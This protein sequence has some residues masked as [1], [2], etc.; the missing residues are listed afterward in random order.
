MTQNQ[1]AKKPLIKTVMIQVRAV[2]TFAN[3][4]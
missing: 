1:T 3:M 4:D 2:A